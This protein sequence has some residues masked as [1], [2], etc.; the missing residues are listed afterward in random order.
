VIFD[1]T[2]RVEHERTPDYH[3]TVDM[4]NQAIAWMQAQHTL[5]P[6]KPFFVYF[7]TCLRLLGAQAFE[8]GSFWLS[9]LMT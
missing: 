1:G 6:D 7:A 5:T 2:V 3:F 8:L 4:T 9:R